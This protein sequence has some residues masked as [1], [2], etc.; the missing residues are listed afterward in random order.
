MGTDLTATR[1]FWSTSA[2]ELFEYMSARPLRFLE[3]A[4]A[5]FDRC[6]LVVLAGEA[7]VSVLDCARS[8]AISRNRSSKCLPEHSKELS[9]TAQLEYRVYVSVRR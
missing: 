1:L 6:F 5:L 4:P 9:D 8:P 2:L 7:V 3:I